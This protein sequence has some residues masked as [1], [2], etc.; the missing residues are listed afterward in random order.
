MSI[1]PI[2]PFGGWQK[3]AELDE[4]TKR[5][6]YDLDCEIQDIPPGPKDQKVDTHSQG[7]SCASTCTCTCNN[8]HTC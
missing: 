8:G 5:D 2:R 6:L 1:G 4:S 3:P 7:Y